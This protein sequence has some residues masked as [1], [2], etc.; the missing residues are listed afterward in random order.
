MSAITIVAGSTKKFLVD[1]NERLVFQSSTYSC[2]IVSSTK[3]R[4]SRLNI[5]GSE[6]R[7]R[8]RDSVP[9]SSGFH[10]FRM[11]PVP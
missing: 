7:R 4:V 5:K 6:R 10:C 1:R 3:S 11:A 9:Y 8:F 2:R